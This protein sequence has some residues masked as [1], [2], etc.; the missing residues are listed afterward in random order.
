M[1]QFV[2][3]AKLVLFIFNCVNIL[4]SPKMFM[5]SSYVGTPTLALDQVSFINLF[6]PTF[7]YM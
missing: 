6:S 4:T 2:M 7:A 1:N 3:R 5:Y